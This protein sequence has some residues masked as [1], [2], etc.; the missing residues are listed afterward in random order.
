MRWVDFFIYIQNIKEFSLIL[1]SNKNACFWV[2]VDTLQFVIMNVALNTELK[3]NWWLRFLFPYFV[4]SLQLSLYW[5]LW[6]NWIIL[7]LTRKA[8]APKLMKIFIIIKVILFR[9]KIFSNIVSSSMRKRKL[10][11]LNTSIFSPLSYK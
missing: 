3:G 11:C 7:E 8:K 9:L 2:L 5:L 6:A 10:K 4:F 1:G